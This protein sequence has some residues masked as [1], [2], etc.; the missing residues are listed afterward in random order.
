MKELETSLGGDP[1]ATLEEIEIEEELLK[2]VKDFLE[3]SAGLVDDIINEDPEH[4]VTM[5]D[6]EAAKLLQ[7]T[8]KIRACKKHLAGFR[9]AI[10]ATNPRNTEAAA[11][12]VTEAPAPATRPAPRGP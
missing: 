5:K 11:P 9:A 3:V 8:K 10:N 2:Q 1:I 4:S 6:A 7:A 12:A